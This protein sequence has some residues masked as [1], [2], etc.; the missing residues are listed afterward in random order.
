MP[1]DEARQLER[2]ASHGD[3]A[4]R[5]RALTQRVREAD[6]SPSR[7]RVA[8]ALG[9]PASRIAVGQDPH[10]EDTL[11]LRDWVAGLWELEPEA[12]IRAAL[13]LARIV[14]K[15]AS[16]GSANAVLP[17][18]DDWLAE[19]SPELE[20]KAR[21]GANTC[22]NNAEVANSAT[23]A[24][25]DEALAAAARCVVETCDPAATRES[26]GLIQ[27]AYVPT[28]YLDEPPP[29]TGAYQAGRAALE[30]SAAMRRG[31]QPDPDALLRA[32]VSAALIGWALG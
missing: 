31:D 15:L 16:E 22:M 21:N 1:D 32:V 28:E 8:A 19:P 11:S 20:A 29:R 23:R 10:A 3:L 17:V 26:F 30:V 5:A 9:D 27:G 14:S 12:G 13:T 18:I 4:T 24:H 7:L 6:L 2:D 25:V